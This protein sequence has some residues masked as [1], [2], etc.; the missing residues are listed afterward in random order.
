MKRF[1]TPL[2]VFVMLFAGCAGKSAPDVTVLQLGSSL[3]KSATALQKSI[4]AR[5][6]AKELSVPLATQLSAPIEQLV[7]KAPALENAVRVYHTAA[8]GTAKA[9]AA[10][11]VQALIA[12]ANTLMSRFF[13]VTIPPGV[14][15]E[16]S[17][18]AATVLSTISSLQLEFARGLGATS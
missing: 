14:S 12:E 2:I 9:L 5:M 15:A 11:D 4:T 17:K 10:K 13:N 3:L 18:L 16:L 8:T 1:L 7:N 6:D